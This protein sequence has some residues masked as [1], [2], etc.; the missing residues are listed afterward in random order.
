MCILK[1]IKDFEPDFEKNKFFSM[2]ISSPRRSGKSHLVKYL[3]KNYL[4]DQYDVY[5]IFTTE[6]NSEYY[7]EFVAGDLIF[8]SY[9]ESKIDKIKEMQ[10]NSL[11]QKNKMLKI[12]II[13]DDIVGRGRIKN[14][15]QILQLF[16]NGRHQNISIIYI[17]QDIYLL[18]PAI[19][20]NL[21]YFITFRTRTAR[22]RDYVIDNFMYLDD[23]DYDTSKYSEK[24]YSK[25][26]LNHFLIDY[27]C[28]IWNFNIQSNQ[29]AD[30]LFKF[31][32][33][34]NV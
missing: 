27:Q 6:Q 18:Q 5:V 26:I 17:T 16:L 11:H 28:L 13:F 32:A 33:P 12:L 23:D 7:S 34:I 31:R 25:L 29:L 19:R 22:D 24:K 8:S 9:D 4:E 20:G 30:I 2:V 10:A 1:Q 14:N 3:F 15:D 21:D